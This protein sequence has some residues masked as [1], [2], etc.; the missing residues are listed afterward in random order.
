MILVEHVAAKLAK[1]KGRSCWIKSRE[2][3]PTSRGWATFDQCARYGRNIV[4]SEIFTCIESKSTDSIVVARKPLFL[5]RTLIG[6]IWTR[7]LELLG[8]L[9]SFSSHFAEVISISAEFQKAVQRNAQ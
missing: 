1:R 6:T 5:M 8:N 2:R 7:C 3:E 9:I 4:N